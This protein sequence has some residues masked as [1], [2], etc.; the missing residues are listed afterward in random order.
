VWTVEH[1]AVLF[2]LLDALPWIL[3]LLAGLKLCAAA[4]IATRLYEARLVS[5][6]TLLTG[7]AAWLVVVLA[8]HGLLVWLL[9]TPFIPSYLLLLVAILATPLAR[10]SAAPL[11]LAWNRH[12]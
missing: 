1:G 10:V 7:A 12:R 2:W 8:L 4:W 9:A 5:D 3:A 11:A 6:R